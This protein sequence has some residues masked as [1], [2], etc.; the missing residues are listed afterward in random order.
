MTLQKNRRPAPMTPEDFRD[1]LERL[2]QTPASLAKLIGVDVR[3]ARRWST[4]AK[5]IPDSVAAQIGALVEAGVVT[6]ELVA[7]IEATRNDTSAEPQIARF[8][9]VQR[10]DEDPYWTI[11]EHDLIADVFYLPGR[12]ERFTAD[13]LVLGA[14]ITPPAA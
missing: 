4:G 13:E 2:G 7:E 1:A 8:I 9:W 14:V 12:L 10:K 6:P 11:A 5:A 3:T